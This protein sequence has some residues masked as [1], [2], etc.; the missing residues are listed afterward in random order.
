MKKTDNKFIAFSISALVL[1]FFLCPIQSLWGQFYKW[2]DAEGTVHVT[3]NVANIPPQYRDQV[4]KRASQAPEEPEAKPEP[5]KGTAAKSIEKTPSGLNRFEVPYRPFEGTARRIIIPVTL[6]S[7]VSARLLLDTGSPGLVISPDLA[8][9][10]G[11]FD[12]QDGNLI[13]TAGGIGGTVPAVLSIVDNVKVGDAT[14]EFLPTTITQ[15]GSDDFEG[16]VGM[17]FVANYKIGIDTTRNVLVFDELPSVPEKPGGHDETW[18][19]HQ[20]QRFSHAKLEWSG[21][22]E[23][24]EASRLASSEREKYSS[25]AKSQCEEAD[26]LFRKL[27]TYARDSAVPITW[28]R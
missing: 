14:V 1:L 6:N 7:I 13:T 24:V 28:R 15:V 3:D 8:D 26:K 5:P 21:Y 17:D 27:E 25:F 2:V 9:R 11:L 4:Q 18:W 19:R 10:L 23:E 16:L 22:L 12:R 20:F